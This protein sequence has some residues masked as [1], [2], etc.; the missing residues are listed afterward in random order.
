MRARRLFLILFTF[1][2]AAGLIYEIVWMRLL[3]L[4]L[5]HTVAA[6]GTVLAAFMGGLAAGALLGGRL[7]PRL[8]R[9]RALQGYAALECV[10]AICALALPLALHA[11]EPL[12]ARAYGDEPGSAFALVRLASSLLLVFIPAAAMGATFPLAIRWFVTAASAAGRE[13]GGLYALNSAGAAVAALLTGFVLIP[14]IGLRATTFVGI[15][16]NAAAAAGAWLIASQGLGSAARLAKPT[17]GHAVVAR[18]GRRPKPAHAAKRPM[19]PWLPGAVLG[20]SGFAALVCEVTF[21]RVLALALGPTTYAFAAMLTAFIAGI[22]IGAA[23]ASR[24]TW[25]ATAPAFWLGLLMLASAA[26]AS[27]AGWFAGTRLPLVI[28]EMVAD[29][30][31]GA[32]AI[33][34]REALYAVG[35]LLPLTCVLGALFPLAAALAAR[36]D[37]GVARDVSAIY[38]LNTI[39][40]VAGSI[41]GAFVF[42]PVFG[43]QGT[44]R[45]AALL[46]VVAAGLAFVAGGLTAW[47]RR[48]GIAV[49]VA[50]GA[51]LLRVP[52]WDLDLL[53]SGGYRYATEV[54]NLDLATGLKAGRLVY[55]REGA[56]ATVSVRRLADTVAL[57]IDGKVDASNWT[58]ML[59]QKL[60]AHLPLLLHPDPRDVAV[61]GLGGGVTLGA[62][63]QH[64]IDR[65]DVVEIS[66]EVVEAS[67]FFADV[68]GQAL[69]DPRTRLL[70]GDGRSHVQHTSHR[71]DVIISEPS[72]PWMAGVAS[73]FTREFFL[74]TRDKL[75]PG[76]IFCQWAHTYDI[77]AADLR[78]IAATFANVFPNGTM[79]LVAEN[80]LLF[81][82]SN[83]LVGPRLDNIAAAWQRPGVAVDLA[84]VSV[85]EPF[86]L[87]SLYVGGPREMMR[88]SQGAFVQ[89]D[90]RPRLEF[91][92]PRGVYERGVNENVPTLRALLDPAH[93]PAAVRAAAAA[94]GALEW[95]H[96]G[97]M[98]L[99]ARAP[100]RA[101]EDFAR[102]VKLDPN[103]EPA[104]IGLIDAAGA[105]Q[106]VAEA[107][108]L[109]ESLAR[110]RPES[111]V[112]RIALARLL[113]AV[114]AFDEAAARAEEAMAADADN[115][116][117]IEQ[118]ASILADVGDVDRLR[119]LVSRMQQTVPEREET[120]YYAAMVSFLDGDLAEVIA[121]AQRV[122]Q[123][124]P[125]HAPAH[126]LIGASSAGLGQLDRAR[127]AFRAS[128]EA[129]PRDASTYANLGLLE[130]ESGNLDS[131]AAHFA[132]ALA[133]D[134]ENAVSEAYLPAA[135][136]ALR[137]H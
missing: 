127:Q 2:G 110:E 53:S 125:Q 93:V 14:A 133:L 86:S 11:L 77:T 94:A 10:I 29:P 89:I 114:G 38:G 117:G 78:S 131:A 119:P 129:S 101:F 40:A 32:A 71:Y 12:F 63:L 24:V 111:A 85:F 13:G 8:G 50:V 66:P 135:L 48:A 84:K 33:L 27:G 25:T 58:D 6:A 47:Q 7:A 116:R 59:T 31:V 51:L 98:L 39:G 136:A 44:L 128:L 28:A 17:P 22:A 121:R 46:A 1:S 54:R 79:W 26:A 34:A 67:S 76:G 92:G 81:I 68:N 122:I 62:A 112:L 41:A 120:W 74:A 108:Q 75:A 137:R 45:L 115:P 104:L 80:D 103:S 107:R 57:A 37:D 102:S 19:A 87:L 23:L 99:T 95:S 5:G 42:V 69:E 134:P 91:S 90:D 9:S 30:S 100:A 15:G 123:M 118:L 56:T 105:G 18:S 109:L 35:V 43:L 49:A 106:R 16:L 130:M 64:G 65:A 72:N 20:L 83:D 97:Q 113:A 61:I 124:N 96:R 82:A 126:N 21:T 70:V 132:E 60:L 73:L 88:Y 4:Q 55:Y 3:S 36:S 52:A